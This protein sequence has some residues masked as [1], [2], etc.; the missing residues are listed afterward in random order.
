[1]PPIVD[2][3]LRSELKVY[4]LYHLTL[5]DEWFYTPDG[6]G[7]IFYDSRTEALEETAAFGHPVITLDRYLGN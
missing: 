5:T 3:I 4:R 2:A 1:M 6:V 7:C